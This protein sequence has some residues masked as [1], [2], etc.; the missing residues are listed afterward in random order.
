MI[1]DIRRYNFDKLA[2]AL[3]QRVRRPLRKKIWCIK[4]EGGGVT[5]VSFQNVVHYR[6]IVSEY[7]IPRAC[8]LSPFVEIVE[9][10]LENK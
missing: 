8:C 6:T 5:R 3:K 2:P 9:S 1:N 7:S 10:H 4:N